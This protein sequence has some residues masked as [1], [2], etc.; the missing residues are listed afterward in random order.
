[1]KRQDFYFR[2]VAKKD[3]ESWLLMGIKLWPFAR[4]TLR[5]SF[6]EI[7]R[8]KNQRAI[9]CYSSK[10]VPV[11]FA[12]VSLRTDY[13]EGSD[14]SPVG[15]LEGIFVEKK[16]R[17]RGLAKKLVNES[18]RWFRRQGCTEM[19]SDTG[20]KNKQSQKF[21][22]GIGFKKSATIVHFIKKI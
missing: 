10:N 11:G 3:F 20:V 6:Q 9:I 14:S 16:Y 21:H 13:V 19:G 4:R 22:R 17:R 18:V 2:R 8:A 5:K 15:Y 7:F 1:M 12:N